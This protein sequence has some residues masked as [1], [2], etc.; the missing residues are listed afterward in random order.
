M[1]PAAATTEGAGATAEGEVAEPS[2]PAAAL[3]AV[4]LK[5]SEA[6]EGMKPKVEEAEAWS[7]NVA[8][9]WRRRPYKGAVCNACGFNL[10]LIDLTWPTCLGLKFRG[11]AICVEGDCVACVPNFLLD[12]WQLPGAVESYK[13]CICY[14]GELYFRD[15]PFFSKPDRGPLCKGICHCCCYEQRFSLP[16]DDAVPCML[17]VCCVALV[18]DWKWKPQVKLPAPELELDERP[19]ALLRALSAAAPQPEGMARGGEAVVMASIPP[20][21]GLTAAPSAAQVAQSEAEARYAAIASKKFVEEN[22][23]LKSSVTSLQQEADTLRAQLAAA[24]AAAAVAGATGGVAAEEDRRASGLPTREEEAMAADIARAAIDAALG[25]TPT[26]AKSEV[27]L[28]AKEAAA[29]ELGMIKAK[30][31]E[32]MS[33]IEVHDTRL[34]AV[35]ALATNEIETP[36]RMAEATAALPDPAL[37]AAAAAAFRRIDKNGDVR[38]RRAHAHGPTAFRS[39]ARASL[40]CRRA[41]FPGSR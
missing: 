40:A 9:E 21:S 33:L 37:L 36:D 34:E 27:A 17:A 7:M 29:A 38:D 28:A 16:N 8:D 15:P 26:A 1:V 24:I 12:A 13:R 5:L 2:A 18:Q 41:F 19:R 25:V 14:D 20:P 32:V 11:L 35:A 3:A 31:N 30:M 22:T 23:A 10:D 4:Q 6:Y 39:H